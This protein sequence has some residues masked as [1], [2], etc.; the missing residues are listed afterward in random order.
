M[1]RVAQYNSTPT[2]VEDYQAQNAH[3]QAFTN[4]LMTQQFILSEGTAQPTIK[5]GCYV[6]HGGSLYIA[7]NDKATSGS[8]ADGS[9][10]IRV[11]GST[12]L[13]L[14]FITDIAGYV[15]NPVYNAM[16]NGIYSLLPYMIVKAGATWT[17]FNFNP[18]NQVF[19]E[20]K[21]TSLAVLNNATIGGTLGVTGAI[22]GASINTGYG[23]NN[24]YKSSNEEININTGVDT[25]YN[26]SPMS[27][28]ETRMVYIRL[29][30]TGSTGSLRLKTPIDGSIYYTLTALKSGT[31]GSGDLTSKLANNTIIVRTSQ[32][33]SN[34]ITGMIIIKRIS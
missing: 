10:Y 12:S 30:Y 11:S 25:D 7:D 5:Q 9:V 16:T 34:D 26:I 17:R 13:T 29:V 33:G 23:D 4:Q 32:A 8:P 14:E 3:L 2:V 28:G 22:S 31:S 21:A 15:W 27:V 18:N 24:V 6:S 1:I 19:G 20:M